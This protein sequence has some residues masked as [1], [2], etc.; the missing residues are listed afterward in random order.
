[1]Q[2]NV[3]RVLGWFIGC[4]KIKLV[5]S[6]IDESRKVIPTTLIFKGTT[7]QWWTMARGPSGH[8]RKLKIMYVAKLIR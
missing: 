5:K 7:T 6:R 3:K 2:T 1:M 4:C 8:C